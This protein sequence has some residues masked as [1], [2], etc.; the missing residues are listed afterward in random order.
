MTIADIFNELDANADPEV[1]QETF[2]PD[3]IIQKLI[4]LDRIP[5]LMSHMLDWVQ[6][7]SCQPHL[8]R[9]L[10]HLVLVLRLL[11]KSHSEDT[12]DEVLKGY[13]KVM[14]P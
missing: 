11:G 10:A 4:I 9:F 13:V 7:D 14:P 3:R 8:I 1:H 2:S 5:E 6:A 12:G